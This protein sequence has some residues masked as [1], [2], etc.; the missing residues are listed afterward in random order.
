MKIEPN[1]IV[2]LAKQ[3][4]LNVI[5]NGELL[6]VYPASLLTNDWL[7]LLRFEKAR[8]LCFLPDSQ[9]DPEIIAMSAQNPPAENVD[10][11]GFPLADMKQGKHRLRQVSHRT[12]SKPSKA[13]IETLDI[14]VEFLPRPHKPS[15][16]KP[17]R[18]STD[19]QAGRRQTCQICTE[20]EA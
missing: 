3:F 12:A 20:Q 13:K 17:M 2:M 7:E 14:F 4:G 8:L 15:A 1:E 9:H 5:R 10:L 6:Q 16:S 18:Q 19:T 11:F